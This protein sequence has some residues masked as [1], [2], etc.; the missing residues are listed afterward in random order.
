LKINILKV[1]EQK[2]QALC[3]FYKYFLYICTMNTKEA[4]E[5]IKEVH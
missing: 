4:L 3:L 2:V 1:P 5:K